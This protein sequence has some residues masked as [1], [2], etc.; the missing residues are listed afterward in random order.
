MEK[1][2][3]SVIGTGN[4]GRA[5]CHVLLN[6]DYEVKLGSRYPERRLEATYDP[7]LKQPKEVVSIKDAIAASN[8]V[9]LAIHPDAQ[10]EFC[11]NY[12]ALLTGKIIVDVANPDHIR[13]KSNAE[14]L[15][16]RLINSS[17]V[18][19][20]NTVSAYGLTSDEISDV[21]LLVHV[22]SNTMKAKQEITEI[23]HRL[24]FTPLNAG[25][26]QSARKL[27]SKAGKLF[28]GW[29]RPC[30]ISFVIFAV[31][32]IYGTIRFQHIN[33]Y[34]WSRLPV[35]V[36]NKIIG[37]TSITLLCCCYLPGS[38]ASFLQL[39]YGTKHRRFASWLDSWMKMRKQLGL[40]ALW[41]AVVHGFFSIVLLQPG[42]Y[43]NWF[44]E[45]VVKIPPH[46]NHTFVVNVAPRMNWIGE[47]AV[48][49]GVIALGLMAILGISSLPS[50]GSI[51]NWRQ[52]VFVQSQLGYI[53]LF[54]S[55]VH[56]AFKA[57]PSWPKNPFYITVQKLSFLS[58][59]L[60]LFT[61]LL[62]LVLLIPCVNNQLQKIR[63]GVERGNRE[64]QQQMVVEK[65][66]T[67][68]FDNNGFSMA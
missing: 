29:G 4:F 11:D 41:T 56:L 6:A 3:I 65:E 49:F 53:C 55:T 40:L 26:L 33:E 62:R 66:K 45:S 15:Q 54:I 5:L 44:D 39:Y 35:N 43:K 14:I 60:P 1:E 37:S 19:A 67:M 16:E 68:K 57:C 38:F 51:M 24:G 20:F 25:L 32:F 30:I 12:G 48:F 61:L 23:I 46:L 52:W 64:D 31:W 2:T 47:G 9:F 13:E 59:P 58:I 21:R 10:K 7:K 36:M 22:A 17:V 42:Y 27:E 63:H 18:K 34:A 8:I 50:V 28:H